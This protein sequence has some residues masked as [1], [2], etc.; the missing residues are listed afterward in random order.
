MNTGNI[1]VI[2]I[3]AN[4]IPEAWE[5]AVIAVW[6]NGLKIKTQYDKPGDPPSCDATV[7]ITVENPFEEPRI[8][9]AIPCGLDFI[10]IYVNEV[11]NGVHDHY[12]NP[13]EGKWQYTYSERIFKYSV[14]GV[15]VIDQVE[16][17]IKILKDCPYSRRAQIVLWKVWDDLGLKVKDPACLQRLFF[18]ICDGKLNLNV[19]IRS[20]DAFKASFLNMIAFTELQKMIADRLEVEVGKYVHIADSFHIYGSYFKEFD[21]FIK[22]NNT[23][24]FEERTYKIKDCVDFFIDGCN[25]LL[26]EKDMPESK[27]IFIQNRK[28]YWLNMLSR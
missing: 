22:L 18:R 4:T 15:R 24:T 13:E 25:I 20:N 6:E 3:S 5:K 10:E 21:N 1:P 9:R 16:E 7:I 11:I 2:N 19:H 23:R 28:D 12:I 26:N 17:V 27:K 8:H 14:P